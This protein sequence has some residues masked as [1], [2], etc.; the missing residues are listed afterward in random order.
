MDSIVRNQATAAQIQGLENAAQNP[1][2][3]NAW[4]HGHDSILQGRRRL[5]V[6][7][8]YQ[9]I[10][11]KYHQSQVMILSSE[12]GSGKSTQVPQL[13]VHDEYASGLQIACTQPRRVAASTLASRVSHE[14]GVVLGEEVG[15]K[16][17][18]DQM[19]NKNEKTTRLVYLTEGVLLRQLSSDKDLSAYACVIIDEAHERTVDLDLLLAL[20][21]KVVR[22]RKDFKVGTFL[23]F[24]F[25]SLLTWLTLIM[26]GGHHVG[27]NE[28]EIVPGLLQQLPTGS[29]YRPQF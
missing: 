6:Y 3:G 27:N 4:P 22:R 2:T 17:R 18:G 9:E 20:L 1:L 5:P 8:R 23:A 14:M 19:V 24:Q 13:L 11:D 10:L 21:K 26:I 7:G 25:T 12:T 29:H 15:Y 28:C 16:I